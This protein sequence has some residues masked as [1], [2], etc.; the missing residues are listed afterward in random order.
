MRERFRV[1]GPM[2]AALAALYAF[3]VPAGAQVATKQMKLTEKQIVAFIAAQKK[4]ASAQVETE[5]EAIA[6]EHGFASLDE[7]DD[8][9]ANIVLLMGSIDPLTHAFVEPPV[10][11]KRRIDEVTA[12]TSLSVDE[13][14]KL[15]QDLNH[16]LKTAEPI[17]FPEN[18]E[19][20]KKYYDK[21]QAALE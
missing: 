13:R 15:L 2:M 19:L 16:S 5:A 18:V 1:Y 14:E 17:Q 7:I 10:A 9:E 8:V 20:V 12:D 3:A 11:I 6:K 21:I 4:M